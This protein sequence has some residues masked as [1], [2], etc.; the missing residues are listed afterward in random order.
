M[1]Q[2]S[3]NVVIL[4][5]RLTAQPE[6]KE[7]AAQ[8]TVTNFTVAVNQGYRDGNGDWKSKTVFAD[9]TA[10]GKLAE[11]ATSLEKG[12]PV[13]IQGA[14]QSNN[15]TDPEG[16][17]RKSF[18]VVAQKISPLEKKNGKKQEEEIPDSEETD[19]ELPF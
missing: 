2:V 1:V 15:W 3:L 5:G 4:A 9:I 18:Q 11:Y 16:N 8:T 19:S 10:W 6:L 14:L 13:I 7:T 12:S 17:M